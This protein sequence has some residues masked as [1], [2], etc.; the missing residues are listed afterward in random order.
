MLR[1]RSETAR[2]LAVNPNE[3]A[4]RHPDQGARHNQCTGAA[5][6]REDAKPDDINP[7][8]GHDRDAQPEP[9]GQHADR[10][11]RDPPYDILDRHSEGEIGRGDRQIA[12]YRRQ[13]QAKAPA[14][15]HAEAEQHRGTDQDE[16]GLAR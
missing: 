16:T 14:H 10:R 13:E 8:A 15:P 6:R 9:V 12:G 2:A 7:G 3:D 11:L 1:R 4:V 5:R